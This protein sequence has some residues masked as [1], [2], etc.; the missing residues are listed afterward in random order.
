M[1]AVLV[2]AVLTLTFFGLGCV[3]CAGEA[4]E[5]PGGCLMLSFTV[6]TLGLAG[7]LLWVAFVINHSGATP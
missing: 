4:K 6:W 1:T 5:W 7:G 2:L 3:I